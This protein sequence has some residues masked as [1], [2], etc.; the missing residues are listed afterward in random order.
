[1]TEPAQNGDR[2]AVL[3]IAIGPL[4]EGATWEHPDLEWVSDRIG[5]AVGEFK[6]PGNESD[7]SISGRIQAMV[8]GAVLNWGQDDDLTWNEQRAWTGLG[9]YHSTYCLHEK[10]EQCRK[11]CKHCDAP[12]NCECHPK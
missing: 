12:C 2:Y 1:M 7:V 3:Q 8:P 6:P 9:H 5:D 10:H 11:T 4:P